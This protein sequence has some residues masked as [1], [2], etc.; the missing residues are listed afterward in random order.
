MAEIATPLIV[1]PNRSNAL[2]L[3]YRGKE[4][5]DTIRRQVV[6]LRLDTERATDQ[7]DRDLQQKIETSLVL[8][9]AAIVTVLVIGFV[10]LRGQI[11]AT[12]RLLE[13]NA[14][15][16]R[17]KSIASMLQDA[18][19]PKGLPALPGIALD[20]AYVPASSAARVGGDWYDAF[21]LPDGR[22]LFSIGDVAGHGVE[23]AIVM[24][25]A[26]QAILV[27]ALQESDPGNVMAKANAMILLQDTTM[28]TALCGFIDP[29]NLEIVYATAGHP[30]PLLISESPPA[31][32]PK[33]GLP[34]GVFWD[35]SYRTFVSQAGIGDLLIL[36]TD[37]V[38]E[39]GRDV[40]AGERRL[41][42]VANGV[43]G[44]PDVARAIYRGIFGDEPPLDDV[45]IL[46]ITFAAPQGAGSSATATT[47]ERTQLPL[48]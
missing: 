9:A 43:R 38:I 33:E 47:L 2:A 7:A 25:R 12:Q 11:R 23:A 10:V 27:A 29:D 39:H 21:E 48:V 6:E 24:S 34:L 3:Q 37:G 5:V 26:R 35:E 32:L 41:A 46:A 18:Y 14:L 16:E 31:F 28:V 1:D 4:I 36:Y 15:Y 19:L 20:A 40:V 8:V 17:E 30:A 22:I 44:T 13:L 45:A 42:E